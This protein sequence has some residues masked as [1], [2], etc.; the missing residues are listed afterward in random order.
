MHFGQLRD[1]IRDV[2]DRAAEML[3]SARDGAAPVPGLDWTVAEVGAHL[4]DG[5][6]R[7]MAHARGETPAFPRLDGSTHDGMAAWNTRQIE[8]EVTERDPQKLGEVLAGEIGDLLD[9]YGPDPDRTIRWFRIPGRAQDALGVYLG[10]LL[11]HGLDL[12]R[13]LGRGWPIGR[14][15][16]VAVFD[17]L[18]P[19]LPEF[20]KTDAAR[21]AAGTY[22]LHFR[23]DGDYTV[24]V[25]GDGGLT[26]ERARPRRADLH[27]SLSPVAYLLVGY[28]RA[29]QWTATAKGQITTW[30]RKPWLALRFADLF[31]R[32]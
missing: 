23:G 20:V 11:V 26:I 24:V 18:V 1:S 10:E 30:G 17:G 8:E 7:F 15:E 4:V 9:E 12:A 19:F 5:T 14:G 27:I 29:S 3:A 25:S 22:H 21:R 6:R 28:G 16:A 32:P 2:G 13:A 31:E